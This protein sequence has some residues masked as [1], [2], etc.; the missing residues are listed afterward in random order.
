M[1]QLFIINK[2]PA[3]LEMTITK[4]MEA[5]FK[6]P[7]IFLEVEMLQGV[8]N[9]LPDGRIYYKVKIYDEFKAEMMLEFCLKTISQSDK[10]C[11]S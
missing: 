4:V 3:L 10:I 1:E 11:K 8:R 5:E 7:P 6:G 2:E 9:E